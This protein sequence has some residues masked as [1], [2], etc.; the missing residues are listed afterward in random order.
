[1]ILPLP[2][3]LSMKNYLARNFSCN[4]NPHQHFFKLLLTLYT[5]IGL[6]LY[7]INKT[8]P[9]SRLAILPLI[10][11]PI[12]SLPKT[13][14]IY[15][16]LTLNHHHILNPSKASVNGVILKAMFLLIILLFN[17]ILILLSHLDLSVKT[18]KPILPPSNHKCTMLVNSSPIQILIRHGSLSM[19]PVI[20]SP[21]ILVTHLFTLF[22]MVPMRLLL[23]MFLDCH[24]RKALYGLKQAPH[25]WYNDL[26]VFLLSLGF[27]NYV[28][29]TSLF[30][31][32]TATTH[33]FNLVS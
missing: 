14:T 26:R 28:M 18:P 31:N 30:Y 19:A 3:K 4:K 1:M 15:H 33:I 23:V 8:H 2:L 21:R 17:F 32:T 22:I 16:L 20:T 10:L 7:P 13:T 6:P 24:L 27:K 5:F 25:A 29:D 11:L 12:L 9:P